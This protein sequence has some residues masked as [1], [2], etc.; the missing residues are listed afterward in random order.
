[1]AA[2]F[3]SGFSGSLWIFLEVAAALLATL[4]AGGRRAFG[5]VLEVTAALLAAL[6]SGHRRFFAIF[7]KI[8]GTAAMLCH[9]NLLS[10]A[11]VNATPD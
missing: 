1:V 2:A 3:A 7:R 9:R 10:S 8:S 11:L 5:I 6:L 4:L